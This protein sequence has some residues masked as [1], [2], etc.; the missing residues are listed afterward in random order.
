[1]RIGDGK[2]AERGNTVAALDAVESAQVEKQSGPDRSRLW[3][4]L[5]VAAGVVGAVSVLMGP[6]LSPGLRRWAAPYIP[7]ND[8]L[9][10]KLVATVRA[11][12]GAAGQRS[13]CDLGSGDGMIVLGMAERVPG[14]RDCW[15]V[16][17]NAWLVGASRLRALRRGLQG[18]ARFVRGDMWR[19]DYSRVDTLIV[20]GV[21]DMMLPLEQRIGPQLPQSAVILS[22]RFPLHSWKSD[23]QL[24]P[25]GCV[26][27]SGGA[28]DGLWA[29]R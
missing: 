14:L 22:G 7:C 12:P 11:L 20:V 29:Y 1:M 2:G 23:P 15:G 25:P 27:G 5:G 16:E 28:V 4:A 6:F 19:Q 9:V 3:W 10:D 18:S 8:S 26:E 21:P 24:L 13:V 17:L